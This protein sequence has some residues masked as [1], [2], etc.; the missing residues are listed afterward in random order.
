[1]PIIT[2]DQER[3][4]KDGLCVSICQK[5][6]SWEGKGSLP[7]VAHEESCNSCGH[8]VMI[9]PSGA[10]RQVDCPPENIYPVRRNLIPS[11][12]Q[13]RE[14]IVSRRSTRTFQE[15][16]VEN[17]IIEKVIDGA[18]FAPSAKN[19]QSTRFIVVQDKS[20][21]Q[22]IASST[23]TWLG[24]VA[25][26][27]KNPVWRKLY[28]LRTGQDAGTVARWASQFEHILEK[29]RQD[30]DIVLFGAP[31]LLL[32]HADSTIRFANEN[33]NLS[34]QN[35]TFAACSLGLG[36]FYTGYV[37]LACNNDKTIPKLLGLHGKHKVYGGLAIGY[38]EITFSQWIDRN[39]AKITWM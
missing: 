26:R 7:V 3:C 21:L 12:E 37:V 2:I 6:L 32:F 19:A 24:K 10:I 14:M 25:K 30:M 34:L 18:R 4:R 33:A 13:V 31:A 5:V 8:C 36:N 9:C 17:E 39:P 20:L 16:P 1:M 22:A 15:R 11:Y 38:P 23:A 27:L 35:A 28:L 29:M